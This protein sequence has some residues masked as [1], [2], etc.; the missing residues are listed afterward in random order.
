MFRLLAVCTSYLCLFYLIGS[1]CKAGDVTVEDQFKRL[2]QNYV[3]F[4]LLIV[5]VIVDLVFIIQGNVRKKTRLF[6]TENSRT[7][8]AH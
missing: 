1:T 6:R 3:R 5:S 4:G 8:S 7:R 2:T